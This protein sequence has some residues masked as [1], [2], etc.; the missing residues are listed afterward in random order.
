MINFVAMKALLWPVMMAIVLGLSA[1]SGESGQPAEDQESIVADSAASVK[2]EETPQQAI[3]RLTDLIRKNPG[4][5]GLLQERALTWYSM[6]SLR[7]ANADIGEA[8]AIY[9]QSPELHYLKGLF[10]K[11][12]GDG[13]AAFLEFQQA[14]S[15]GTQNPEAHYELGQQYFF[16]KDYERALQAYKQAQKMLPEDPQYVFAQGFLEESRGNPSKAVNLYRQTLEVDSLFVK[17]LTRIHDVYFEQFRAPDDA[18]VYNDR[19]LLYF[20]S[21]PLGQYQRGSRF[22]AEAMTTSKE[23]NPQEF[24]EAINNAVQAFSI[25]INSDPEFAEAYYERGYAYL[26]GGQ[27][28]DLATND[29][30]KCI[31]LDPDD[32]KA[33]FNMGSIQEKY[34]DY[35]TALKYYQQALDRKPGE[36]AFVDAINDM[37][38]KLK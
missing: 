13:Q 8:L 38:A 20:P 18:K 26:L 17:A 11:T 23:S 24:A 10:A 31:E 14:V 16:R 34:Q 32:P 37:K 29:F 12:A 1:C 22:L 30:M 3:D 19:L 2:T 7:Q 36:Q 28:I 9:P 4:D 6:D 5:Y 35:Q 33:Y 25:A 21:H 27:R 15:M